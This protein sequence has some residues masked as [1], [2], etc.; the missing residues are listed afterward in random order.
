MWRGGKPG[1]ASRQVLGPGAIGKLHPV[2]VR[3]LDPEKVFFL[4]G[5]GRIVSEAFK[6]VC[7]MWRLD[8]MPLVD[9]VLPPVGTTQPCNSHVSMMRFLLQ[10]GTSGPH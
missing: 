5:D 10:M 1:P 4:D 2:S 8:H 6:A 3:G 9:I 7:L